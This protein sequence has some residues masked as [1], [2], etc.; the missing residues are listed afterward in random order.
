MKKKPNWVSGDSVVDDD[1]FTGKLR[2]LTVIG[3]VSCDR[4]LFFKA[5]L[6]M[7]IGVVLLVVAL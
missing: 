7:T 1:L 3:T 4:D 6:V 5:A 2:P